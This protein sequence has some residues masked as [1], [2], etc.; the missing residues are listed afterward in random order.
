MHPADFYELVRRDREQ[1]ARHLLC[2]DGLGLR[3]FAAGCAHHLYECFAVLVPPKHVVHTW[4]HMAL[5]TEQQA[6]NALAFQERAVG[7]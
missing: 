7:Q 3:W 1:A 2:Y 4:Q 5:I 6:Q